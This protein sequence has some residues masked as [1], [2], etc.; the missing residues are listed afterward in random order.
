LSVDNEP[1]LTDDDNGSVVDPGYANLDGG[2]R[3]ST[4]GAINQVAQ[5]L[6]VATL[7]AT[8]LSA[9]SPKTRSRHR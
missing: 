9:N 1:S 3:Y 4:G 8:H 6:S 2:D 5:G 7:T